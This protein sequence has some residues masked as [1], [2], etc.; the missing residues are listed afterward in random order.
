MSDLKFVDIIPDPVHKTI[1][2]TKVE[3]M[4]LN[5]RVMRRL[6]QIKQMGLTY[7]VF[8]GAIHTRYE[9]SI[10]VMHIAGELG[11]C[12][13]PDIDT[14][15]IK[16]LRI[17]GLLHDIG[18]PPLSH[19]VE[20]VLI[21]NPDYIPQFIANSYS[22]EEFTADII[23]TNDEIAEILCERPVPYNLQ[24]I[25]EIASGKSSLSWSEIISGELGADRIDYI[26]RDL[27]H[28]G[29]GTQTLNLQQLYSSIR[30]IPPKKVHLGFDPSGITSI[31]GLLI[32]RFHLISNVHNHINNISI[33][34][35]LGVL[36]EQ[37]FNNFINSNSLG[38]L[39]KFVVDLHLQKCDIDLI[40]F[41]EKYQTDNSIKLLP[42]YEGKLLPQWK[43]I[44][45]YNIFD[46]FPDLCFYLFKIANTPRNIKLLEDNFRKEMKTNDIYLDISLIKSPTLWTKI[47][48]DNIKGFNYLINYSAIL[49]SLIKSSYQGITLVLISDKNCTLDKDI[50]LEKIR[51]ASITTVKQLLSKN[52]FDLNDLVL[53][54]IYTVFYSTEVKE[55]TTYVWKGIWSLAIYLERLIKNTFSEYN[56]IL[57]YSTRKNR[58]S[59]EHSLRF[60]ISIGLLKSSSATIQRNDNKFYNRLDIQLSTWGINTAWFLEK[61]GLRRFIQKIN[62]T[63]TKD[64]EQEL[65]LRNELEV[66]TKRRN[67]HVK[68][69]KNTVDHIFSNNSFQKHRKSL[70]EKRKELKLYLSPPSTLKDFFQEK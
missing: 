54:L 63:V 10:G 18:H 3:K 49:R 6:L 46:L 70:H 57:P 20:S 66:L 28:S 5:T 19:A 26:L 53:A 41:I 69:L 62:E 36:L 27:Y 14:E 38:S 65:G 51:K 50:T 64:F 25:A 42:N 56:K 59:I 60:L 61:N 67:E 52:T 40:N 33:N 4:L 58:E 31:E 11:K 23:Q 12:L 1:P 29:V 13:K 2:I 30:F 45:T 32:S 24:E 34:R 44:A 15:T 55:Q 22:H 35:K 8:P 48:E 47:R 17:A 37:A 21:K 16:K 39:R 43:P 7:M 68:E 9:H